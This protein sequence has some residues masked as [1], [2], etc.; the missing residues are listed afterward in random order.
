MTSGLKDHNAKRED[1]IIPEVIFRLKKT[2]GYFL[3]R[4]WI[5]TI[6]IL[7]GG[8]AGYIYHA[9]QKAEYKSHL[10]F[11]LDE[12]GEG[13]NSLSLMNLASQFGFSMGSGDNIFSNENIFEIIKSRRII[14]N[15]LLSV[16]T[17]DN[18]AYTFIEYF[19]EISGRRKSVP[20]IADIHFPPAQLRSTFNYRQDS[21]LYMTYQEF[22][23]KYISAKRPRLPL[24]LYEVSVL[25]TDEK[26]TK[27]L[28]DIIVEKTT[29]YYNELQTAKNKKMLYSLEDRV[30]SMKGSLSSSISKSARIKDKNL[31][32]AFS[33]ARAP[34]QKQQV[35][36]EVYGQ[37]YTEMYK[38]MELARFQYLTEKP[39]LQII[40]G[41]E[42]PMQKI[43]FGKWN[44]II[45]FSLFSLLLVTCILAFSRLFKKDLQVYN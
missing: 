10:I 45:L 25:S 5:L 35:N 41:A 37:A 27:L 16:D 2:A 22:S 33:A 32:P 38:Y 26:F 17:F 29:N 24:N 31:N 15:S 1:F 13:G 8:I 4:W 23:D 12:Q 18:K 39:L 7:F 19:L 21:L 42:Y 30:S 28:T 14:E 20:S 6:A 40:D 34:V 44:I 36:I 43:H 3:K 9:M 11:A